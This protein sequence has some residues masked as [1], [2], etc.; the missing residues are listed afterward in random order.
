[1]AKLLKSMI[2]EASLM[3]FLRTLLIVLLVILGL[4]ILIRILMPFVLRYFF[5]KVEKK[6]Y[7]QFQQTQNQYQRQTDSRQT[8]M[9]DD[10][11]SKESTS[12]KK[13]VGEYIDFEEI[14]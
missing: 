3:G 6:I 7:N 1:M 12:R 10:A 13:K 2:A 5:K 11:R 8:I 9:N 4:R 14:K